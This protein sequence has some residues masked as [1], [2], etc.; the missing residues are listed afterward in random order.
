V[1]SRLR[2]QDYENHRGRKGLEENRE[3]HQGNRLN[4]SNV[5]R[6]R[7]ALTGGEKKDKL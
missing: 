4:N 3:R 5:E 7:K 6:K 2:Q 1:P